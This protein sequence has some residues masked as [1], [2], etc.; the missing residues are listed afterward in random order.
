MR[1]F[2]KIFVTLMVCVM[3]LSG[4]GSGGSGEEGKELK[5]A[6]ELAKS[7]AEFLTFV[8]DDPRMDAFLNDYFQRH[9]RYN[10]ESVGDMKLGDIAS[11]FF[12]REFDSKSLMWFDSTQK[13]LGDNRQD[14][15]RLWLESLVTIDKYGY[16]W[17]TYD[18]PDPL[19]QATAFDHSI[20]MGWP[21]P[22]YWH[23]GGTL[24]TGFEFN[25]GPMTEQ[26][27]TPEGLSVSAGG[28]AVSN[29]DIRFSGGFMHVDYAGPDALVIE[30]P[31]V[32]VD[33]FHSPYLQVD[34]DIKDNDNFGV[35]SSV[36]DIVLY[37]QRPGDTGWDPS[38]SMSAVEWNPTPVTFPANFSRRLHFPVYL[39][40]LWGRTEGNK[41]SKI[42]L[43]IVKKASAAEMDIK[44]SV[45]YIRFQY[46]TRHSV[47]NALLG[48]AAQEY[49]K[50]TGDKTFLENILPR[51]RAAN[52]FFTKNMGGESGLVDHEPFFVGH[53][54]V[55]KPGSGIGNGYWDITG[56]PAKDFYT[57]LYFFKSLNAL[58][59]LEE[60]AEAAGITQTHPSIILGDTA[61]T[62]YTKAYTVSQLKS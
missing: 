34:L 22:T 42:K 24:S 36:E 9:L 18:S 58:I 21:F 46:D 27:L 61:Q 1:K 60:M 62:S 38:R 19:K 10:E 17:C 11:V 55:A 26:N 20:N 54:G 30:S 8:S 48:I 6:A 3:A 50:N 15:I 33:V 59:Y 13:T 41:I 49:Y 56:F 44:A 43:E 2:N 29:D 14:I 53:D 47:N 25:T 37:W 45:N 32:I 5:A 16:V 51:V 57:N 23:N 40:P 12:E 52:L 39:N 4:C 28:A 7:S 35:N 31:D